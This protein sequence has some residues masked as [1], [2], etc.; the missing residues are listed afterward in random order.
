MVGRLSTYA[1]TL[2]YNIMLW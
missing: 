1:N 2:K